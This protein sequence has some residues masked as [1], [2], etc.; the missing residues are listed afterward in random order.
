MAEGWRKKRSHGKTCDI[1]VGFCG[2]CALKIVFVL[3]YCTILINFMHQRAP[4]KPII[5]CDA[6][7]YSLRS[8]ATGVEN[9]T[10]CSPTGWFTRNST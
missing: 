1:R 9:S 6:L 2:W 10:T 3:A 7:H 5:M 8:S 4:H